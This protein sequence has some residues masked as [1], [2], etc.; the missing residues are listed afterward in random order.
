MKSKKI[1]IMGGAGYVGSVLSPYLQKIG[2]DVT[3]ADACWF[4]NYL[5][6]E[7]KL[8]QTDLFN[9][10]KMDL[11]GFDSV[12][13]LAGLSNDPMA[14][15][16]PKA[17]FILNTALPSYIG[18][19]AKEAGI[20]QFL[21]ASSCSV[22]GYTLN[23]TYS[24][25]SPA[26]CNY[27]YGI[28]KLQ[29]EK[30]LE[31]LV[32]ENFSVT[33]L[34]QGTVCGYSPRMRLDLAMNTMFKIALQHQKIT[35]SNNTIWRPILGLNDLCEAYSLALNAEIPG[36][37]VFNISS[38]NSTVGELANHIIAYLEKHLKNPIALEDLG[39]RDFRNY[40][41]STSKAEEILKFKPQQNALDI[42][43]ELFNHLDH[44]S[45][46]EEERFYN[47]EVFKKLMQDHLI[48][49]V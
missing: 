23:K 8:I 12:I 6:K 47:I 17:N 16:S 25:T 28:S 11:L 3:V 38:F 46:F 34:R 24:E 45:Q 39:I 33:I 18:F 36:K 49:S 27:P 5:P 20:K 21:F 44:F 37:E 2:H 41:V 19:V 48:E 42:I 22:Y 10:T 40:K 7:I 43:L 1:L 32:D 9:L 35:L 31:A 14:E 30:G 29:G 4:G 13:F 26:T 15:F